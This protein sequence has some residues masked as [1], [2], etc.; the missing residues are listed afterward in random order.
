MTVIFEIPQFMVSCIFISVESASSFLVIVTVEE[1]LSS[2]S[3]AMPTGLRISSFKAASKP[4]RLWYENQHSL[5]IR[6]ERQDGMS[7]LASTLNA[8]EG[9]RSSEPIGSRR[10]WKLTDVMSSRIMDAND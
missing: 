5:A 1:P 6:V 2:T 8:T 7:I 10:S 4:F 3:E 9:K